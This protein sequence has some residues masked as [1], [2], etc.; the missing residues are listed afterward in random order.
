MH[1]Q[2]SIKKDKDISVL[3]KAPQYDKMGG[4][5]GNKLIA[6]CVLNVDRRKTQNI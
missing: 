3:N 6:A 4:G 2:K 1:G 5:G